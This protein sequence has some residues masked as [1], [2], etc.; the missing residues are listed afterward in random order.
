MQAQRLDLCGWFA[1]LLHTVEEL[2]LEM[3]GDLPCFTMA[4]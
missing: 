4:E 3:L 1:G 2:C